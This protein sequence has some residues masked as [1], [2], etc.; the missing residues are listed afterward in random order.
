MH[1]L[2]VTENIIKICTEEAVKHKVTA[3]KC[4]NLQIGELSGLIPKCIQYYFDIASK[5][6]PIEGALLNVEKIPVEINCVCCGYEGRLIKDKYNCPQ[7]GSYD[8]KII[9][10]REFLI[11]SMEVD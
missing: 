1:E 8:V 2:S 7:C 10:G 4:I 11:K 5:G 3:V 6:T 9:R